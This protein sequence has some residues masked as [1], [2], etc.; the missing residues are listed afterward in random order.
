LRY[1]LLRF[2]YILLKTILT[3]NPEELIQKGKEIAD[4][5][6]GF[7]TSGTGMTFQMSSLYSDMQKRA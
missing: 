5:T 6:H 2:K 1:I 3:G 4:N 7:V